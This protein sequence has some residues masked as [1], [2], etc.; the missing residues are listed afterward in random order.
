M[1][2]RAVMCRNRNGTIEVDEFTAGLGDLGQDGESMKAW[3]FHRVSHVT[4]SDGKLSVGAFG[5]A[6]VLVRNVLLG[7]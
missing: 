3:I 1:L 7:Y 4:N 2:C 5:N 6:L